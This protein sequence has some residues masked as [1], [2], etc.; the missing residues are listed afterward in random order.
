MRFFRVIRH[1]HNLRDI[2]RYGLYTKL[3]KQRYIIKIV[4]NYTIKE[5]LDRCFKGL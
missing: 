2:Y 4:S 5:R 3:K 1:G